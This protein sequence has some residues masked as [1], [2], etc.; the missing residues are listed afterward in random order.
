[1][2]LETFLNLCA[3]ANDPKEHAD[4]LILVY[5]DNCSVQGPYFNESDQYSAYDRAVASNR[6]FTFQSWAFKG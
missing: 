2:K 5:T 1:M 3:I 4:S 6:P